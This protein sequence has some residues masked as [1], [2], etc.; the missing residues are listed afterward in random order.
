MSA[1][2]RI[3]R[4]RVLQVKAET[5]ICRHFNGVQH[6]YCRAG[7]N[8]RE[9]V[10]EP[11]LGCMTRIP[12]TPGL[13]PKCGPLAECEKRETYTQAEAE[14]LVADQD[15]SMKRHLLVFRAAHDDAKAKG[16]KLG[17]GGQSTMLCPICRGTFTYSVSGYNGHKHGQCDT[18]GCVSWME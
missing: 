17:H 13:E 11:K 3:E 2:K 12:C 10:G 6:D 16:L 4:D 5:L 18:E 7:V 8:Y 9:L 15:A 1:T 14:Q